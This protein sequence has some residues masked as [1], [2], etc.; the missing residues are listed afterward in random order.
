MAG[1]EDPIKIVNF[2]LEPKTI[3]GAENNTISYIID[4]I[5]KPTE[6]H[7]QKLVWQKKYEKYTNDEKKNIYEIL[8]EGF[9]INETLH[10]LKHYL[11]KKQNKKDLGES[12][13]T[14]LN[15]T[16]DGKIHFRTDKYNTQ[17]LFIDTE[18]SNKDTVLM[19][20]V[21]EFLESLSKYNM[22]TKV[23]P[24]KFIMLSVIRSNRIE[25][26]EVLFL[27]ETL[28]FT[29]KMLSVDIEKSDGRMATPPSSPMV[30]RN[31]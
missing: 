20:P 25:N 21:L 27:R 23:K 16:K 14:D 29:K 10:H 18:G 19:N 1:I 6:I 15:I 3:K 4:C 2:Y 22:T 24:S 28:D 11:L 7:K 13:Q 31:K 5:S 9:F 8:R 30:K 26:N 12:M 17:N